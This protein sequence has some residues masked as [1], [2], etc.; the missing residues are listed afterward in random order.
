MG[1]AGRVAMRDRLLNIRARLKLDFVVVVD[2]VV[3]RGS[4][5]S[6][7]V[8]DVDTRARARVC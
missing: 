4:H 8:G 1:R 2:V 3:V 5:S 6:F 7:A